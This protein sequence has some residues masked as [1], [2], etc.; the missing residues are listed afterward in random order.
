MILE[1][2]PTFTR[3]ADGKWYQDLVYQDF[4]SRRAWFICFSAKEPAEFVVREETYKE[5]TPRDILKLRGFDSCV[6]GLAN[7]RILPH[8]RF[9]GEEAGKPVDCHT[10]LSWWLVLKKGV[11][12]PAPTGHDSCVEIYPYFPNKPGV[13]FGD[14][15]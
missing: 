7:G 5:L 12:L 3:C 11:P 14:L 2:V 1:D 4:P 6:K 10:A 9:F 8:R 13:Y 15:R